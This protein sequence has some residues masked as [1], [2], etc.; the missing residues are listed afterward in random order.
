MECHMGSGDTVVL[1]EMCVAI[2]YAYT[3]DGVK[4]DFSLITSWVEPEDQFR[5]LGITKQTT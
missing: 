3:E 4:P 2:L 1:G 5:V